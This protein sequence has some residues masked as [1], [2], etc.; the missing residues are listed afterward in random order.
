VLACGVM[1]LLYYLG[2]PSIGLV[3]TTVVGAGLTL[4]ADWRGWQLRE[5]YGLRPS[6]AWMYRPRRGRNNKRDDDCDDPR[7]SS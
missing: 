5:A 1:A 7:D 3:V 4:V 6:R 2:H